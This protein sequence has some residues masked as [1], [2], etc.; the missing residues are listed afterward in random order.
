MLRHWNGSTKQKGQFSHQKRRK[1]V[2]NWNQCMIAYL[3]SQ[4]FLQL[5]KQLCCQ[6]AKMVVPFFALQTSNT[7]S[8]FEYIPETTAINTWQSHTL[9]NPTMREIYI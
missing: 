8:K 6:K 2:V 4:R 9:S 5:S 3:C 1:Y 7:L